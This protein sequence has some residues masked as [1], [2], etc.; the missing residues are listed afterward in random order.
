[1]LEC[2]EVFVVGLG[3]IVAGAEVGFVGLDVAGGAGATGGGEADVGGHGGVGNGSE[4]VPVSKHSGRDREF[5]VLVNR[6]R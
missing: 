3:A 6:V 5:G 4:V 2:V 1:M